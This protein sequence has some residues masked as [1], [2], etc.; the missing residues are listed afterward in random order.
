[1]PETKKVRLDQERLFKEH[2]ILLNRLQTLHDSLSSTVTD[3]GEYEVDWN[4][5][6]D[7][8]REL[9][10]LVEACNVLKERATK[11]VMDRLCDSL[12]SYL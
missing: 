3:S 4:N 6:D 12:Q 1:M 11:L 10:E 9:A 5:V 8:R 2:Q 7:L